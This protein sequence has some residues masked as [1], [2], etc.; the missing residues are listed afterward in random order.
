MVF[1]VPDVVDILQVVRTGVDLATISLFSVLVFTKLLWV[2]VVSKFGSVSVHAAVTVPTTAA[3]DAER[4]NAVDK[5]WL[6]SAATEL[7]RVVDV[8]VDGF[9]VVKA[10]VVDASTEDCEVSILF[11]R[12]SAVKTDGN[13]AAKLWFAFS[14]SKE[15]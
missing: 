8:V 1:F 11:F 10:L 12:P 9:N 2:T 5:A 3:S 14:L 4:L 15:D 7:V 13:K 6:N